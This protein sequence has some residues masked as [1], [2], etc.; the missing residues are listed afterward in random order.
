MER[1]SRQAA[2]I[3]ELHFNGQRKTVTLHDALPSLTMERM[4]MQAAD[5]EGLHFNRQQKRVTSLSCGCCLRREQTL[6]E[7]C[8]R[9]QRQAATS[10]LF[11]YCLTMERMSMQAA[12]IEELHFNRQRPR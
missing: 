7:V 5:I 8:W 1:T 3:E 4:S 2:D 6:L 12:A 11:D 10:H 9:K